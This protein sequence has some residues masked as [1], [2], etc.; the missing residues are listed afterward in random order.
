MKITRKT[1][2]SPGRPTGADGEARELLLTTATEL[3]AAEGVAATTFAAIAKRAGLTPAMM[4]YYF[5]NREHLLDCV[6]KEKIAPLI[7]SVWTPVEPGLA[8]EELIRGIVARL[9]AGIEHNPWVPSTWMREVLNEGGLLRS[10]VLRK[11]PFDKVR[12]LSGA[13]AQAQD[14]D[15]IE[16]D[17]DPVLIVFSMLGLVML[18][19]A[20]APFFA[21]VFHRKE[22]SPQAIGRHITALL[23]H[24]LKPPGE[25]LRKRK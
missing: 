13:V 23:L 8:P 4:H 16:S 21:E 9:V 24:G 11:L 10:R 5:K 17:L 12:I 15:A 14:R 2:R 1:K 7:A 18:H 20:T 25:K 6:V 3:F 22:P 19:H